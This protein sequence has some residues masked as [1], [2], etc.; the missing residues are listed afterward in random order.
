M[1]LM[2]F[3]DEETWTGH[4]RAWHQLS[5]L[6]EDLTLAVLKSS[7]TSLEDQLSWTPH[8][9]QPHVCRSHMVGNSLTLKGATVSEASYVLSALPD[10]HGLTIVTSGDGIAPGDT[11]PMCQAAR[12]IAGVPTLRSL[13]FEYT[14]ADGHTHDLE[15]ETD[16]AYEIFDALDCQSELTRLEVRGDLR[17]APLATC[18]A[19]WPGL[20]ALSLTV[21]IDATE[22]ALDE[23]FA[24]FTALR[25]LTALELRDKIGQNWSVCESLT[26]TPRARAG[27][28]C[29]HLAS[30]LPELSCLRSLVLRTA[31]HELRAVEGYFTRFQDVLSPSLASLPCLHTLVLDNCFYWAAS[32]DATSVLAACLPNLQQLRHLSMQSEWAN[33]LSDSAACSLQ[34][35]AGQAI[36]A[37]LSSLNDLTHVSFRSNA[38]LREG[39]VPLALGMASLPGITALDLRDTGLTQAEVSALASRLTAVDCQHIRQLDLSYNWLGSIGGKALAALLARLPSLAE[40]KLG[41][42]SLGSGVEA[43]AG[44]ATVLKACI[45]LK[46]LTSLDLYHC[47]IAATAV[48]SFAARLSQLTGLQE[49]QLGHNAIGCEG[50]QHLAPHIARMPALR[51][52]NLDSTNCGDEGALKLLQQLRERTGKQQLC[53]SLKDWCGSR[54][55][56]PPLLP[57]LRAQ[58]HVQLDLSGD[59]VDDA[60]RAML[61]AASAAVVL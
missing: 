9:W 8:G 47:G 14:V 39:T 35:E 16:S 59:N 2:L 44:V 27:G 25:Q 18:L 19:S 13:S 1:A 11:S 23:L 29:S 48:R 52:L 24:A 38:S 43:N 50:V 28:M 42:T 60:G 32:S 34:P 51:V 61:R 40:L 3:S 54:V 5:K 17:V 7:E 30:H 15:G 20:L 10:L 6:P 53:V 22:A 49:L 37:A 45:S 56:V 46:Q 26:E 58:P 55:G 21:E 41:Q 33:G 31:P 12:A 4:R 36:G 57:H